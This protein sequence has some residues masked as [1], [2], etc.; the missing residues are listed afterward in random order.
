MEPSVLAGC[1]LVSAFAAAALLGASAAQ[2]ADRRRVRDAVRDGSSGQLGAF[3]RAVRAGVGWTRPLARVVLRAGAARAG[4]DE[5]AR[6]LEHRGLPA[7]R[8]GACSTVLAL[9][10]VAF[11]VA[12]ALSGDAAA[13]VAVV[14]C[15]T[16]AVRAFAKRGSDAR[17]EEMR[18]AV[19]D[20]LRS[21]GVCFQAGLSLVQTFRQT[22]SELHGPLRASFERAAHVL[23]TGGTV[24][25]ALEGLRKSSSTELA[26]VAVALDIQHT[27]GGS[28]RQVLDAAGDS[29]AAETELRR[30]M[31]VQTAQAKLSARVVS[32]MPFV[33]IAVFMLTTEDFLAPFFQSAAG[34]ALLALAVAMQASG[35]L[36]VRRMLSV[37]EL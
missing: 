3:A 13:G 18:D 26:F 31:R 24:P 14:A 6:A 33:L 10:S 17:S 27:A 5:L 16:A 20:V 21:L 12:V 28:I 7:T 34:F 23:E 22:A 19:P 25:E 32:V 35:V 8:E 29:M 1:C 15:L 11:V 36:L 30:S 2:A 37:G 4:A 9:A